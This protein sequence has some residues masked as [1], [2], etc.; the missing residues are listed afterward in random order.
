MGYRSSLFHRVQ[1]TTDGWKNQERIPEF[2]A[3]IYK[4]LTCK[5][6]NMC[7]TGTRKQKR[8]E[9]IANMARSFTGVDLDDMIYGECT[10]IV[11][12]R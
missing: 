11:S 3:V 2:F 8:K 12:E 10:L 5:L 1:Y 4:K 7:Y 9:V 6:Y